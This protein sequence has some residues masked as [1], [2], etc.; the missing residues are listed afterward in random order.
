MPKM[1]KELR[2][3]ADFSPT[4]FKNRLIHQSLFDNFFQNYLR[5]NWLLYQ[6]S[7]TLKNKHKKLITTYFVNCC[8]WSDRK[9]I[10]KEGWWGVKV[11]HLCQSVMTST[12]SFFFIQES[13]CF[14]FLN[15][16]LSKILFLVM[17]LSE[18]NFYFFLYCFKLLDSNYSSFLN[19]ASVPN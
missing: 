9:M 7:L 4:L 8:K 18:S 17:Y 14:V 19:L 6:T 10:K 15:F 1:M 3:P 16:L 12:S 11:V 13:V 2:L 5:L